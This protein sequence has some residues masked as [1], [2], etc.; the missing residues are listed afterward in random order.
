MR[1]ALGQGVMR[2]ADAAGERHFGK[3]HGK[4][5]VGEI[6]RG[7]TRAGEDSART[8]SPLRLLGR[9]IDR[10][11]RAVAAA[12][13]I[14]ELGGL[15]EPAGG[16]ADEQDGL[17]RLRESRSSRRLGHI[18]DHAD[19]ADRRGRQNAGALRLVV[20]RDIAGDD[21][22]IERRAPP[23]RCPAGSRRTGP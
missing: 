7:E 18:R 17:A 15:A 9:K 20:E 3:R 13:D 1:R 23:R 8:K 4:A 2:R 5:A 21:R 12:A 22:E 11:R 16:R 6:M 10:R 19:A 14:G